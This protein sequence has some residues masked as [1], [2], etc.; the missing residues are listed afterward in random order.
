M[1]RG[2]RAVRAQSRDRA[3]CF[4]FTQYVWRR[5]CCD[6]QNEPRTTST[7]RELHYSTLRSREPATRSLT[8][9]DPAEPA[10]A[11]RAAVL[12]DVCTAEN[13]KDGHVHCQSAGTV[14]AL[15][16][17]VGPTNG[18]RGAR[19]GQEPEARN[20]PEGRNVPYVKSYVARDEQRR[21]QWR[22][23]SSTREFKPAIGTKTVQRAM[24][25]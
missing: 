1:F 11:G 20:E 8:L 21:M 7:L 16:Q 17:G 2:Q 3:K 6:G 19:Q 9:G 13:H 22:T 14:T 15:W 24:G 23:L 12:S 4:I 5:T 18:L 10:L 25:R